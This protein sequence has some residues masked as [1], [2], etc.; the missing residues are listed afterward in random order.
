MVRYYNFRVDQR[1]LIK[2]MTMSICKYSIDRLTNHLILQETLVEK[3][4]EEIP[5]KF[6]NQSIFDEKF[7]FELTNHFET[8]LG[9]RLEYEQDDIKKLDGRFDRPNTIVIVFPKNLIYRN[10][11]TDK[12]FLNVIFHEFTHFL[13]DEVTRPKLSKL[14]DSKINK[15]I[16]DNYYLPISTNVYFEDTDQNK[17]D[18]FLRYY[19]QPRERSNWAFSIAFEMYL[20]F[21][22]QRS[23]KD[24]IDE[25]YKVIHDY[26]KDQINNKYNFD[27]HY[28]RLSNNLKVLFEIQYF[29]TRVKSSK[30]RRFFYDDF[31]RMQKLIDKYR[32]RFYQ[33]CERYDDNLILK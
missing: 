19:L 15:N 12:D 29:I 4:F 9:I 14:K 6:K 22:R 21:N 32:D 20:K 5:K 24:L 7:F 28:Y 2:N 25:N 30:E 8:K 17:I 13:V 3:F 23:T 26:L 1:R 10:K 31:L 33:Y 11:I 16:I 27:N 18:K